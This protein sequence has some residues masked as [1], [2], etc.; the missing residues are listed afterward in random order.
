MSDSDSSG[1]SLKPIAAAPKKKRKRGIIIAVLA[2]VALA[3]V[4][5]YA[6]FGQSDP[7]NTVEAADVHEVEQRDI[8]TSVPV[9]G[10][11]EAADTKQVT[12][13]VTA[14]ITSISVKPG[15]RVQQYQVV[16][17]L[18]TTEIDRRILDEEAALNAA[19]N[20]GETDLAN[21]QKAVNRAWADKQA[22]T[23]TAPIAGIV[24]SVSGEVGAP[25]A[26]P[27]LTIANDSRLIVSGQ[28]KEGDLPKVSAGQEV[29]FTT[30]ATGDKE[31]TGT[32]E[33]ISPIGS[34]QAPSQGTAS[35]PEVT[36]PVEITVNGEVDE[37]RIG[38]SAKAQVILEQ[39]SGL[40]AVPREAI[41]YDEDGSASV[42]VLVD[43]DAGQTIVEKRDVELGARDNL[44][45]TVTNGDVEGRVLDRAAKY[46]EFEGQPVVIDETKQEK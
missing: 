43:D 28:L 40:P 21:L 45:V 34:Q 44:Y 32:V 36:F 4:A 38:S 2:V 27:I 6:F 42:L 17:Q 9:N 35:K 10:T 14:P 18:D 7:I 15:D 12:T 25:P 22:T 11:V 8:T 24:A 29:K 37:L 46:R 19:R 16:A 1:S 31:F 13:T 5:A 41:L 33:R 26:G 3:L 20:A 30:A 39:E 23:I